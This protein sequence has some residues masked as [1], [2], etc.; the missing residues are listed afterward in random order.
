MVNL[1]DY[2]IASHLATADLPFD[3]LIAAAIKRADSL[4]L[5]K[6]ARAFPEHVET[7]RMRYN[8][9]GAVIMADGL[10]DV[11]ESTTV[12]E[13]ADDILKYRIDAEKIAIS[14][15][16]GVSQVAERRATVIDENEAHESKR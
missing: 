9:P 6:L 3:A 8:A 16:R 7:V 15:L 1:I 5:A 13:I 10:L 2:M 14:Y 11:D 4:N 12:A